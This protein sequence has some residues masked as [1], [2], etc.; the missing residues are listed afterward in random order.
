M[1]L[2]LGETNILIKAE[3]ISKAIERFR[4]KFDD[5][6]SVKNGDVNTIEDVFWE[7]GYNIFT[8]EIGN[9]IGIDSISSELPDGQNEFF[10]A[11]ASVVEEG[12]YG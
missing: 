9:I 10:E 5:Y 6:E 11:I 2:S 4:K 12:S 7:F 1:D 8:D 3:N